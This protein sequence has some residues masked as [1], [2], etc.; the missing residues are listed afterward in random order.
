MSYIANVPD[1]QARSEEDRV[2]SKITR[3]IIPI[4]LVAYIFAFLDRINIGYV[5]LEMQQSLHLSDA[6][7]GLG[8]GLFFLTYLLFEMPSNLLMARIGGRKTFLRIM[9][10]WGLTSAATMF[11][12][13][14]FQ[15]YVIRLLL[16]MFEAGFFPGIILYLSYW[17]P[18]HRRGRVTGL[19]L[20]GIPVAGVIGG[21]LTGAIMSY[22]EGI[23]GLQ[24]WQWVFL[25]EGLPAVLVGVGVYLLLADRPSEASWLTTGEKKLVEDL[26][27][28]DRGSTSKHG[29]LRDVLRDPRIYMLAF[30]YFS[31]TC[32]AYTL[33]FWLPTIIRSL[34]VQSLA[35]LGWL[36]A[37]PYVFGA[38]GVLIMS[39]SSDR[40]RERRWHI[41]MALIFGAGALY[42]TTM[43]AGAFLP[44]MVLLCIAAFFTFSQALFWTLPPTYLGQSSA[45][46]GIAAISSLGILGGF[47]SPTLI[48]YLNVLTGDVTLG[49]GIMALLIALGG[50]M[51]LA[52]PISATRVG[53]SP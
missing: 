40:L 28:T 52:L 8:A 24:G 33:A 23:G 48:G 36:S 6:V 44:T 27:A 49:L 38:A 39:W 3:R 45:A 14:P 42:L 20:L 2:Y 7:Y 11:V 53:S 13:S 34:G 15:F 43:T 4:I 51:T 35:T 37:V 19:F 26:L 18:S 30:I 41:A 50:L 25:L 17:Y 46:G 5:K 21:P 31:C 16:G 12:T 47:V 32:G 22:F 29:N 9:V 1:I 10:L